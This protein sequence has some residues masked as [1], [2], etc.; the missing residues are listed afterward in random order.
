[1]KEQNSFK[2]RTL[3]IRCLTD[4]GNVCQEVFLNKNSFAH[5]Y[6]RTVRDKGHCTKKNIS[7]VLSKKKRERK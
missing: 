6:D 5:L 2:S 7:H 1:M 4:E 3:K